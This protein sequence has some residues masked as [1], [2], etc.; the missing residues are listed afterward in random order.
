MSLTKILAQKLKNPRATTEDDAWIETSYV[1]VDDATDNEPVIY[2]HGTL[3][4]ENVV[5]GRNIR[6]NVITSDHLTSSSVETN[7]L[8]D[9][10]VTRSKILDEAINSDKLALDAVTEDKIANGSVSSDKLSLNAV[11]NTKLAN[12]SVSV[13]KIIDRSVTKSKI[14]WSNIF[15]ATELTNNVYKITIGQ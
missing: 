8:V 14:D 2:M 3:A 15:T 5:N 13:D 11:T 4:D 12:D 1:A 9:N 7:K 6:N 10:A